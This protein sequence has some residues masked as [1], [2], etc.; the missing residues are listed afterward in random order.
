MTIAVSRRE[1]Y[2]SKAVLL[3]CEHGHLSLDFASHG[4]FCPN[5]IR[6]TESESGSSQSETR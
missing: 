4:V 2:F 6:V 3:L 5:T 1:I